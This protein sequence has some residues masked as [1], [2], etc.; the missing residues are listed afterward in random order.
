MSVFR[1]T[2][3]TAED[4]DARGVDGRLRSRRGPHLRHVEPSARPAQRAENSAE[5]G[6]AEEYDWD[7]FVSYAHADGELVHPIVERLEAAGWS[8]WLDRDD[9]AAGTRLAQELPTGIR[10]AHTFLFMMSAQSV[11]SKWCMA[12]V[13]AA[14]GLGRRIIP[15]LLEPATNCPSQLEEYLRLEPDDPSDAAAIAAELDHLL[16]HDLEWVRGHRR[17]SSEAA[18]WDGDGR[19]NALLLSGRRLELAEAWRTGQIARAQPRMT[20]T[21]AEFL[22]ASREHETRRQRRQRLA[23]SI[24]AAALGIL[25]AGALV[26]GLIARDRAAIAGSRELATRANAMLPF[27]PAESRRLAERAESR[28]RTHEAVAAFEEAVIADRLLFAAHVGGRGSNPQNVGAVVYTP[29]GRWLITGGDDARIRLWDGVTAKPQVVAQTDQEVRSLAVDRAGR[30]L[31]VGT[32]SDVQLWDL[33]CLTAVGSASC[34]AEARVTTGLDA[35]AVADASAN[36]VVTFARGETTATIWL[37]GL[38]RGTTLRLPSPVTAVAI[39]DDGRRVATGTRAGRV[40]VWDANGRR[41]AAGPSHRLRV[42]ALGFGP[43]GVLVSGSDDGTVRLWQPRSSPETRLIGELPGQVQRLAVG[44]SGYVA[45]GGE[46]GV[47]YTWALATGRF[48]GALPGHT[49]IVSALRYGKDGRRL[50]S[51]SDEGTLRA[52]ESATGG[53]RTVMAGHRSRVQDIAIST[54]GNRAASV[55]SDG[56]LRIWDVARDTSTAELVGHTRA[57]PSLDYSRDGS[58]IVTASLDGTARVWDASSGRELR[59]FTARARLQAAVFGPGGSIIVADWNGKASRWDPGKDEPTWE[60]PACA[61]E[62]CGKAYTLAVSADGRFVAAGSERGAV[63]LNAATGD[64]IRVLH[65]DA[66]IVS[67]QFD[68][69]GAHVLSAGQDRRGQDDRAIL[70]PTNRTGVEVTLTHPAGDLWE[71]RLAPA[72]EAILTMGD[73]GACLWTVDVAPRCAR[74]S[75]PDNAGSLYSGD[76]RTA[77]F[78]IV[79]AGASGTVF[80]FASPD[81]R[82]LR[83]DGHTGAIERVRLTAD[84]GRVV[85]IGQDALAR[86]WDPVTGARIARFTGATTGLLA[87][88]FDPT[89]QSVAVASNDGTARVYPWR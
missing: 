73:G 36:R 81:G 38:R 76:L 80:S 1:R 54:L 25:G 14:N 84:G 68:D 87:I 2:A 63:L 70:A 69:A 60:K 29:N 6:S 58:H 24:T 45:A 89:S 75:V 64:R 37:G 48:V 53:S 52:W 74:L 18:R 56:E 61:Q 10:D 66:Y 47:I 88:A 27:D 35:T 23:I 30:R 65:R 85:S 39:S 4:P 83:L 43:G 22:A 28:K 62:P 34:S 9:L 8:I 44:R 78:R 20:E 59:R 77:P 13:D 71:A 33:G 86:V 41:L 11:A 55:S 42:S 51:A 7:A 17:W 72:G 50:F 3:D 32:T 5:P 12:E 31:V 46:S 67:L 19:P 16:S 82:P 26:F 79:V 40:V 57:I 15:V 21:L 49:G